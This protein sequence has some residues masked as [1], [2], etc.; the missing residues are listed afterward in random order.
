MSRVSI[1]LAVLMTVL[2]FAAITY[3]TGN[4]D[5]CL[6]RG[7]LGNCRSRF[8]LYRPHRHRP[9]QSRRCL[10]GPYR[11]RLRPW[12]HLSGLPPGDC[13][14]GAYV[15]PRRS[16]DHRRPASSCRLF[17]IPIRAW[18]CLDPFR[19]RSYAA[20]SGNDR[21]P[22]AK[23]FLVGGQESLLASTFCLADLLG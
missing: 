8:V 6:P 12:R 2:G 3:T 16:P 18:I 19:R 14:T 20:F 11:C 7:V 15:D 13:A 21:N 1:A 4:G 5:C 9:K 10:E 22:L 23:K 17:P